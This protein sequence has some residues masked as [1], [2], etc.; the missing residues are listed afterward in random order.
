MSAAIVGGKPLVEVI[1][2]VLGKGNEA[3]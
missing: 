3:A 1:K 2:A